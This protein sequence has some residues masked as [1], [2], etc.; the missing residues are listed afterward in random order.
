MDEQW[1]WEQVM[2]D[3]EPVSK[4]GRGFTLFSRALLLRCP[5]C[6]EGGIFDSWFKLKEQCPHCE[7]V[8]A[9][10]ESGY[11]LGSMALDLVI[12]LIVWFFGF[13]G[14]LFATW[15]NPPWAVLQWGSVV[16]MIGVPLLLYPFSH[17]LAIAL[18]VLVRPDDREV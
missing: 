17:T 14:I 18:D 9:R 1:A 12:P 16:F 8:F 2:D 5:I 13:F 10:G 6:G 3:E 11:Q 15:P 4:R 7:F